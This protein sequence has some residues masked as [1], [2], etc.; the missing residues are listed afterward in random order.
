MASRWEQRLLALLLKA[1]VIALVVSGCGS[2]G[3]EPSIERRDQ[4]LAGASGTTP[5]PIAA[6][7]LFGSGVSRVLVLG[8]FANADAAESAIAPAYATSDELWSNEGEPGF[9]V[10][11]GARE[12]LVAWYAIGLSEV[13]LSCLAGD[14]IAVGE[15]TFVLWESDEGVP[16]LGLDGSS[17][18]S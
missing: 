16:K 1:S 2:S 13:D 4:L 8:P 6:E 17:C 14:T 18:D 9:V 11:L 3:V 10:T 15:V 12:S 7:T 5:G